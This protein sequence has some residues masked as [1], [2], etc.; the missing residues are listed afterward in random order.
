MVWRLDSPA[1]DIPPCRLVI[2]YCSGFRREP[3]ASPPEAVL[4]P[5]GGCYGD[6]KG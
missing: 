2:A 4:K 5:K 3:T 6:E 1:A